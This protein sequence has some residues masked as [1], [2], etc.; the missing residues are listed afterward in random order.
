[1]RTIR[2]AVDLRARKTPGAPYVIAPESGAILTYAQLQR[3]SIQLAAVL[4]NHGLH[5]GD[6]VAL[7][8]HNS[9]QTA[10]LLIGVMYAGFMAAP[11][12]LLA[13]RSQLTY[14]LDHSDSKLVFTSEELAPRVR[15]AL[16]GV[17]RTIEVIAINPDATA[18]FETQAEP[19]LPDVNED[20]DALLMYTSG[21]TGK[22]KGCVLSNRSVVA[23]GEFTSSAHQL[24]THDRVL[25]AMPLY[26]INGQIVT[27]VA[28]LVHGG[29]VVM[30]HR[31]SASSYW[32]L[33]IE[34]QCTWINVVPTIIAYL[35]NSDDPRDRGLDI[36][37]VRFC[38]SAS[39][40]LPPQQHRAFE[41]KFGIGIIETFGMTET[42]APCFTNP[43]DRA[44]R[45]IGSPGQAYGN[46]AKVTNP[47]TGLDLPP[48]TPGELMIRGDNVMT[49]YYKDPQ[50][51][52]QTLEPDG[53]MHTGD[54]GYLDEDG[55]VFVTGRI[56]ELIIKGGEN[57]A[58][59]EIDEALL[60]HPAVLEAAAVGIPD[61]NYGQEIMACV[62]LK[63][64][65]C[66]TLD[67]LNAFSL[68]EL[69]KYKTPKVIKFVDALPKGPSGKVQR[70]K[71]LD[72]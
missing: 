14:V 30:P 67:E 24:A 11:L 33:V 57:I 68:N 69:G 66:C 18:I 16:T 1:M 49:E 17:S 40:P 8:L 41:A 58:P 53:W 3:D 36:S 52:A 27:T 39:A 72:A 35:L 37:R 7:M 9:Y 38:R 10:R 19:A 55:F 59:R 31:F 4:F 15:E 65:A 12:N 63:P 42:N 64:G 47:Q 28:P 45:K 56:K 50:A 46:E 71:L 26:H 23:G 2:H 44:R 51:T 48:N 43:Y 29:S 34:H 5:K 20:D 60:K 61:A 70:L 62:V 54:V 6:K 13:Q 25:C 32:E 22:P 21:T